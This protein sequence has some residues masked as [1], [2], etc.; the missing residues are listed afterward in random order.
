MKKLFYLLI[1]LTFSINLSAQHL[2][3]ASLDKSFSIKRNVAYVGIETS[4]PPTAV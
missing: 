2:N 4:Q 1:L 3:K